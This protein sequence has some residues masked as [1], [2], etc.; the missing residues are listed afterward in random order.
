[1]HYLCSTSVHMTCD[2]GLVDSASNRYSAWVVC[3]CVFVSTWTF[4]FFIWNVD[5]LPSCNCAL[6]VLLF[7]I[8]ICPCAFAWVLSARTSSGAWSYASYSIQ[9]LLCK[10]LIWKSKCG[11]YVRVNKHL[12][13]AVCSC[14]YWD[15]AQFGIWHFLRLQMEILFAV[16]VP[17][18]PS[19]FATV[20]HTLHFLSQSCYQARAMMVNWLICIDVKCC[21]D[22]APC[23]A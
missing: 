6:F 10:I 4:F 12:R 23:V 21:F 18:T 17:E 8:Q 22:Y 20:Y 13:A 11:V 5:E 7:C 15:T 19:L 1:M 2:V 3:A 9:R 14:G 16:C